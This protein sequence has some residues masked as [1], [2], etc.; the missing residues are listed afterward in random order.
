MEAVL[1]GFGSMT[2]SFDMNQRYVQLPVNAVTA[3]SVEIG[4]PESPRVAPPGHYMLFLLD[5]ARIPSEAIIVQL[6]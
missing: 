3:V 4:P 6:L 2:H 5:A 1:I